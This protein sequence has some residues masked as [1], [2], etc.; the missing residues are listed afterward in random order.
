MFAKK[1]EISG[2]AA[3]VRMTGDIS[4]PSE[5][6]NLTMT[7]APRLST[8]AAVGAGVLVNP[9]V[10][11][12]VLLGGEVLK[13]PLERVLAAQYS[14][15][16]KW[17]NP[18]VERIGRTTTPVEPKPTAPPRAAEVPAIKAADTNLTDDRDKKNK[19]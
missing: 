19:P 7:V 18:E 12:G 3:D 14:V 11:L 13:S 15:T 5:R 16:G 17:D 6:V 9:L 1:F 4:L 8:V 10:G 2:P